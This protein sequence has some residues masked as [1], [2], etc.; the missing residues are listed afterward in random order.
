MN[1]NNI[2]FG[3]QS[4]YYILLDYFEFLSNF[5]L[6]SLWKN[7]R[8][9]HFLYWRIHHINFLWLVFSILDLCMT[10]SHQTYKCC[11][12]NN[13]LLILERVIFWELLHY[14]SKINH[15]SHKHV[16][17]FIQKDCM[18]DQEPKNT[19]QQLSNSKELQCV[20]PRI[21]QSKTCFLP[22]PPWLVSDGAHSNLLPSGFLANQ[23]C[24]GNQLSQGNA[25]MRY[26]KNKEL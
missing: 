5:K 20:M 10:R 15:K 12:Y 21:C 25:S 14:P 7:V 24:R 13:L 22:V 3:L 6:G 19:R 8:P 2:F 26:M 11:L 17:R 1:F 23:F 16:S 18:I 4:D 9:H